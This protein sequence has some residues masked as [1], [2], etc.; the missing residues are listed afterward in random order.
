MVCYNPRWLRGFSG[1]SH[2]WTGFLVALLLG[3]RPV[4]GSV[5]GRSFGHDLCFFSG[6]PLIS[7]SRSISGSLVL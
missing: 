2:F 4:L 1:G 5:L 6:S 3:D 7:L